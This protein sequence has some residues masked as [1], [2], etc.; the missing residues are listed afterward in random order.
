MVRR[1]KKS[2]HIVSR[3][4]KDMCIIIHKPKAG[5][6]PDNIL[7]NA[8]RINE[9]GFGITFLD[10]LETIKTMDYNEARKLVEDERPFVAHYRYATVGTVN[11]YNCHPFPTK[12]GVLYSNGTVGNLGDKDSCDTEVV[13]DMLLQTPKKHWRNMLSMTDVRF[14]IISNNG[15]VSRYGD[16]HKKGDVYYSKNNCFGTYAPWSTPAYGQT[17][18][19]SG[20]SSH[21]SLVDGKYQRDDVSLHEA[22]LDDDMNYDDYVEALDTPTLGNWEGLT[23]L[24]VY[25]TLKKGFGNNTLL[26]KSKFLAYANSEESLRMSGIGIPYL[27]EGDCAEGSQVHVELFDVKNSGNQIDIDYL[28]GHPSN[29]KRTRKKFVTHGGEHIEAWVYIAQ[30]EPRANDEF[31][32]EFE[33]TAPAHYEHR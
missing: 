29:Y 17:N 32:Q 16:W 28:E 19:G 3:N 8:E 1:T 12:D 23:T 6:I 25:G 33:Y 31:Y 9:D 10:T 14:C 30:H 24:A 20:F 22:Y 18:Y 21:Y 2:L 7:D 5:V 15:A 11:A 26:G 13:A 27:Y 4:K